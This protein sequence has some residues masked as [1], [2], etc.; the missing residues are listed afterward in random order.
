MILK[1]RADEQGHAD[2]NLSAKRI[3]KANGDL[4]KRS[5]RVRSIA[6]AS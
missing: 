5:L 2:A 3:D 4:L 1:V 6:W